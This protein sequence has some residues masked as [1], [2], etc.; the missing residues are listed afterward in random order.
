MEK[1]H[2]IPTK[3]LQQVADIP[4]YYKVCDVVVNVHQRARDSLQEEESNKALVNM[5]GNIDIVPT[6]ATV[7][8]RTALLIVLQETK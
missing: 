5:L 8:W 6:I 3:A 7:M 2:P 4:C 1:P